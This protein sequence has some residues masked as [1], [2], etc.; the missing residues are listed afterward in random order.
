MPSWAS[1]WPGFPPSHLSWMTLKIQNLKNIFEASRVSSLPHARNEINLG[2]A[3]SIPHRRYAFFGSWLDLAC[4][5]WNM[6]VSIRYPRFNFPYVRF[7]WSWFKIWP[8]GGSTEHREHLWHWVGSFLSY[9]P[10]PIKSWR[11]LPWPQLFSGSSIPPSF[12]HKADEVPFSLL[13]EEG[14]WNLESRPGFI[15]AYVEGWRKFWID[16]KA[17][18]TPKIYRVP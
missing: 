11:S 4:S 8:C 14:I 15:T 17:Y 6:F 13:K 5:F 12:S 1:I 18:A 7:P 10:P 3:D 9:T 16:L 2:L